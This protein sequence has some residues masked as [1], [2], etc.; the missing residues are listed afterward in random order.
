MILSPGL[1][2]PAPKKPGNR[3]GKISPDE[4]ARPLLV[5]PAFTTP[6]KPESISHHAH[7]KSTHPR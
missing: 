1:R 4:H 5:N 7:T 6:S 3:R 2:N